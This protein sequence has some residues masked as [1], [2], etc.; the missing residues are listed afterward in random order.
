[1]NHFIFA[2]LCF[3]LTISHAFGAE[4]EK[5]DPTVTK[6]WVWIAAG[7]DIP[8][9]TEIGLTI[10]GDNGIAR[11]PAFAGKLDI[12]NHTAY[13]AGEPV[14]PSPIELRLIRNPRLDSSPYWQV[15]TV[16]KGKGSIT[17]K[18]G[19]QTADNKYWTSEQH[20]RAVGASD[21]MLVGKWSEASPADKTAMEKPKT[22]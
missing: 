18:L 16:V 10:R 1:M 11:P 14:L 13:K 5:A 19:A 4:R 12:T 8:G 7:D 22:K 15:E 21:P 3:S 17:W 2:V 6:M 9:D 20:Q